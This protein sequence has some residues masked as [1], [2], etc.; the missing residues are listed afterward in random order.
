ML[1]EDYIVGF[2]IYWIIVAVIALLLGASNKN[3]DSNKIENLEI[4]L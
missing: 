3:A 2:L 1:R 4:G